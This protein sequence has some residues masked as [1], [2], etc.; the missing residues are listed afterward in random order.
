[1]ALLVLIMTGVN[2]MSARSY[3]EFEFWFSSIKVAAIVLFIVLA[4]AFAL[5]LLGVPAQRAAQNLAGTGGFL[6][7]GALA[8]LA[9]VTTV[10]FSLTG[11]EITTVAAVE[12]RD[13]Q[14]ALTRMTT[15]VISRILLFYVASI[16]LIVTIVPW[17]RVVPGESP[18][19]HALAVMRFSWA[20]QAMTLIILTAVLSC[21]NSAFYVTSRVLFTLA[22]N[23]DAPHWLVRL[24]ARRVPARSVMIGC[25]AGLL[26][27]GAATWSPAGVFAFLINAS[28]ALIV[29]VY[30]ATACSQIRLRRGQQTPPPVLMW[31]F[32]WASALAIAGMLAVLAAMALSPGL[33]S[34]FYVSVGALAVALGAYAVR[35]RRRRARA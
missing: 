24:N 16:F 29:F 30:L 27:I 17:N 18:F 1:G 26:G 4:G 8:V 25:A 13:P 19:T 5:G 22:A 14:R 6:P 28:G 10:F 34:Q 21:L 3:G 23:G 33:A 9:G 2:L 7:H 32:P 31:L 20:G 35:A 12:S 11:A 15:A